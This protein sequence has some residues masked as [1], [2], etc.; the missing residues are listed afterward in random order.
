MVDRGLDIE[1]V[2]SADHVFH[3][4]EPQ[5]GHDLAHLFGY[6]AEKVLDELRLSRETLAQL[7][8]LRRHTDGAGVEVT[9]PAS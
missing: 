2:R 4:A 9:D 5:L 6:E 3:R 7:W 1:A 8:V